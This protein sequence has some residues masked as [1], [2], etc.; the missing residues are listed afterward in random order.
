PAL[1]NVKLKDIKPITI[2]NFYNSLVKNS[3]LS[4]HSVAHVQRITRIILNHAVRL[5]VIRENPASDI[6]IV[7]V[8]KKEQ[9]VWTKDQVDKFSE[10]AIGQVRFIA[11]CLAVFT[12]MRQGAILGL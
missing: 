2:Q 10:A 11:V 5:K 1:G 7:K 6:D 3:G 12:G 4:L 8:P 9:N